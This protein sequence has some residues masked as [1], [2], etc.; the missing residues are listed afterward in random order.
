MKRVLIISLNFIIFVLLLGMVSWLEQEEI[1]IEA[2]NKAYYR[3]IHK[4]EKIAQINIWLDDVVSITKRKES[5]P[6]E[7]DGNMIEFFD[8]NK[9]KYN[10]LVKRYFYDDMT[11]KN[12]DLSYRVDVNNRKTIEDFITVDYEDGFLQ[13]V[14][15]R[16]DEKSI[17]GKLQ[18][19]QSY[20]GENNVSE[21]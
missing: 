10:L 19:L 1:R 4:L 13:F 8:K 2:T 21:F 20:N 7:I 14:E 11:T 15:F 5:N 3:N 17:N 18:L 6:E 9:N 16:F 12:L